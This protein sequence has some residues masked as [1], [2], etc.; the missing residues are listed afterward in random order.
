MTDKY[1]T[2]ENIAEFFD[3]LRRRKID[4]ST[5]EA[6]DHLNRRIAEFHNET[7]D[8]IIAQFRRVVLEAGYTEEVDGGATV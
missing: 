4:L 1:L 5:F 8:T 6:S 3:I 7:L 2:K